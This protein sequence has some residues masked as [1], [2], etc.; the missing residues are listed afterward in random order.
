MAV[1]DVYMMTDFQTFFNQQVI[2]VYFY[3]MTAL[4]GGFAAAQAVVNSWNSQVR[5]LVASLQNPTLVHNRYQCINLFNA[6]EFYDVLDSDPGTAAGAALSPF[7]A[8]GFGAPRINALI[9][10]SKRRLAGLNEES[11]SGNTLIPGAITTA[12]NIA[13]AFNANLV[14]VPVMGGNE[15]QPVAVKRI[16]YTTPGGST[17]YR[18]PETILELVYRPI[19]NWAFERVTTQNSRKVGKGV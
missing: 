13:A 18:L 4:D 5:I 8:V 15:F 9:R 12:N 19:T 6:G 2:N 10:A 14:N 11:L 3:R 1:G 16:K 7:F 17:A